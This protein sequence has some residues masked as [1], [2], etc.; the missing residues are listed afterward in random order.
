M[1]D[2]N[3][4]FYLLLLK[5]GVKSISSFMYSVRS[6]AVTS[7]LKPL[8]RMEKLRIIRFPAR[9][10]CVCV[11]EFFVPNTAFFDL[12]IVKFA[13]LSS[14]FLPA[15]SLHDSITFD[16]YRAFLSLV[17]ISCLAI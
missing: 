16:E 14:T 12:T 10:L 9:V 7:L 8:T 6:S 17:G 5:W 11:P 2:Y 4:L 3:R 15:F 13:V 1:V